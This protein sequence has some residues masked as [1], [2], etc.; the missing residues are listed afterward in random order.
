MA[1]ATGIVMNKKFTYRGDTEETWSNKY[2]LTG[3]PPGPQSEW[4]TLARELANMEAQVLNSAT[5]IIGWYGYNDNSP[6]AISIA[7]ADWEA[8]GTQVTGV[9][10]PSTGKRFAGDQA[11]MVE[12]KTSRKSTRGKWIYLRKYFHG[13][14]EDANNPDDLET[15]YLAALQVY[16]DELLNGSG[17]L[18]RKIRSAKQDEVL[19][20]RIVSPF[21]TTRT[22][23]RRGKRP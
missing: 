19:Q 15:G 6:N 12:W 14:F 21:T 9:F 5:H 10:V 16:G 7:S 22:L 4:E 17:P 3:A 2:W 23:H 1:T 20:A 8:A 11:A 13:G 18:A